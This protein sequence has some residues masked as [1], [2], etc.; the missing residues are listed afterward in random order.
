MVIITFQMAVKF[1]IL[2]KEIG[3]AINPTGM[4]N[5]IQKKAK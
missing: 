4:E 2:E 3:N 1:K 5:K